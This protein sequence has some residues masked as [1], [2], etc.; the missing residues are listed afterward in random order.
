MQDSKAVGEVPAASSTPQFEVPAVQGGK[1]ASELPPVNP[2]QQYVIHLMSPYTWDDKDSWSD[3][4]FGSDGEVA[5]ESEAD[6]C[7]I[8]KPSATVDANIRQIDML[9]GNITANRTMQTVA[10]SY[11]SGAGWDTEPCEIPVGAAGLESWDSDAEE[12]KEPDWTDDKAGRWDRAEM[13][14]QKVRTGND[15]CW[16]TS[17]LLGMQRGDHTSKRFRHSC[18]DIFGLQS[19][20]KSCVSMH[21]LPCSFLCTQLTMP[22]FHPLFPAVIGVQALPGNHSCQEAQLP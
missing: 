2:T 14:L 6:H 8:N 3:G 10:G 1:V 22:V 20:A 9:M 12:E 5:S 15:Q 21:P 17:Q 13:L 11:D 16:G 4:S 19:L 7:N 18:S